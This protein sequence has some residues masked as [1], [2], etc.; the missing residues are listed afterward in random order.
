[1][2][3]EG[4]V[5][6]GGSMWISSASYASYVSSGNVSELVL[7]LPRQWSQL[8]PRSHSSSL[9]RPQQGS[10]LVRS[11]QPL[12]AKLCER[13]TFW[14]SVVDIHLFREMQ[15]NN[16]N[17]QSTRATELAFVLLCKITWPGKAPPNGEWRVIR[18]ACICVGWLSSLCP[19]AICTPLKCAVRL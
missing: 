9:L 6:S 15:G 5:I 2:K 1:M 7:V 10:Q 12:P 8:M 14:S 19:E 17:P 16:W 18:R 3:K 13:S 11:H 4:L